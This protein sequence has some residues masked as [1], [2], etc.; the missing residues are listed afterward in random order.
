ML[1]QV[2]CCEQ[3]E[4]LSVQATL[5]LLVPFGCDK[6]PWQKQRRGGRSYFDWQFQLT[7]HQ[8]GGSQDVRKSK[9]LVISAYESRRMVN[10]CVLVLSLPFFVYSYTVQDH[11]H[12]QCLPYWGWIFPLQLTQLRNSLMGMPTCQSN[13]DSFLPGWLSYAKLTVSGNHL[14]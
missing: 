9:Q 8:S 3:V 2:P 7:V 13:L 5:A 6:A 14:A 1:R 4:L 11:A 10:T 12:E